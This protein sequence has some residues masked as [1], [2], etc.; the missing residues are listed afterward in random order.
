MLIYIQM[1]HSFSGSC[2]GFF[3][4]KQISF[5]NKKKCYLSYSNWADIYRHT[6]TI[7]RLS[8]IQLFFSHLPTTYSKNMCSIVH[9]ITEFLYGGK[10]ST[11][12]YLFSYLHIISL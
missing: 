7:V 12:N 6:V 3:F 2:F 8:E 4:V 9:F 11:L 5:K 1:L 10:E